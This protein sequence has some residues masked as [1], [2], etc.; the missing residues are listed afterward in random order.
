MSRFAFAAAFV[1]IAPAYA[2]T[3]YFSAIPDLPVAAGL[4]ESANQFASFAASEDSGLVIAS[5]H[6][7][8]SPDRVRSFYMDNLSAL[9]WAY[10]PAR[11]DED[12]T[13]LRG[14]ERLVLHIEAQSS[15]TYLTVRLIVAPAS[16]NAD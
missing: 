14:R 9:G 15:E 13:F 16:M 8:A 3:T 6:G 12:L 11:R 7:S 10:E 4:I 1:C 5:A 2:E